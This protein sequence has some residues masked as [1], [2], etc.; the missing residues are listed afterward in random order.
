[1]GCVAACGRGSSLTCALLLMLVVALALS[2]TLPRRYQQ[3]GRDFDLEKPL[4]SILPQDG[5]TVVMNAGLFAHCILAYQ[6][7]LNV[8]THLIIHL[9]APALN[10]RALALPAA[11]ALNLCAHLVIY[12]SAPALNTRAPAA[13]APA[14]HFL[15]LCWALQAAPMLQAR[16]GHAP[17]CIAERAWVQTCAGRQGRAQP[18][19]KSVSVAV[20]E[21]LRRGAAPGKDWASSTVAPSSAGRAGRSGRAARAGAAR[22]R[23]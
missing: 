17:V 9:S 18:V 5:W 23:P 1:L 12:L 2:L 14:L 22:G 20:G 10:T 19:F 11:R 16:L 3:L 8:W 7:D 15:A 21:D 4:T 13:P 6:I